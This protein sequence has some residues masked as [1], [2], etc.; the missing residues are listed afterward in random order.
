MNQGYSE[1]LAKSC[2]ASIRTDLDSFSKVEAAVLEN[3]GYWLADAAIRI[4]LPEL[5]TGAVPELKIP[6]PEWAGPED[7]IRQALQ[8]SS[9]RTL[10][11]RS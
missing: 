9:M 11:G 3:H 6:H 7:K 2:I 1:E 4:H 8:D 5:I 10:L